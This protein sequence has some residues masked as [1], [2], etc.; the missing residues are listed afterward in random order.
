MLTKEFYDINCSIRMVRI[1]TVELGYSFLQKDSSG[2]A[3]IL[4]IKNRKFAE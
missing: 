2:K 4:V 1:D 3:I